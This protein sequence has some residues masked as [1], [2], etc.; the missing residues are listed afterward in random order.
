[1]RESF[2]FFSRVLSSGLVFQQPPE[3]DRNCFQLSQSLAVSLSC[4][5]CLVFGPR[6]SLPTR[7][8]T[9]TRGWGSDGWL[10][11]YAGST[12]SPHGVGCSEWEMAFRDYK[13]DT[14]CL[15]RTRQVTVSRPF[16]RVEV[17]NS[18]YFKEKMCL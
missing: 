5:H 10:C 17:G 9:R 1:M 3:A 18:R 14:R 2:P 11:R 16:L 12:I 6:E 4:S 7:L 15:L 8:L 13:P